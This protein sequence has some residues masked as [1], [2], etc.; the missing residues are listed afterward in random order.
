MLSPGSIAPRPLLVALRRMALGVV[1]LWIAS[2]CR[3]GPAYRPPAVA[4]PQTWI[5]SDHSRLRGAPLDTLSWWTSFDDPIL[6]ELM[7]EARRQNLTLLHAGT[8]IMEARAVL[9]VACGRLG[10]QDQAALGGVSHTHISHNSPSEA[11]ASILQRNAF[12]Q[13]TLG[14]GAAW[15]LDF[16]GK[17]RRAVT[18]ASADVDAAIE[19][20]NDAA[21]MLLAETA[22][23]YLQLRTLEYRLELARQNVAIQDETLQ[24]TEARAR[25]G[26]GTELDSLQATSILRE[27]QALV[28]ALEAQHRISNNRLCILLGIPPRD[29]SSRIGRTAIVPMPRA[30]LAVGVPADL[31]RRRPDIRR[32]E[33]ELAAQ[34]E[35]IGIAIADFYPQLS[36]TGNVGLD[37]LDLSKLYSPRSWAAVAGPSFRWN[38]LNYGRIQNGVRVQEARYQG[39]LLDYQN[40]VLKA[41]EEAENAIVR[42][43]AMHE[44]VALLQ[45]SVEAAQLSIR[46]ALAA[47][48]L[49]VMDYQRVFLLQT[50]LVVKQDSLAVAQ[51]ELAQSLVGVYKSMGGGWQC[52]QIRH[53][54]K[55]SSE[56]SDSSR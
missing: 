40:A 11:I 23:S 44:R 17:Y 6:N 29:L 49:G 43:L 39:L 24:T 53:L 38:I 50:Q 15:E 18:A 42:F 35:R 5:D 25:A 28:P 36:I 12:D 34:S 31:L 19:N 3:V 13:W 9:G 22:Q 7:E 37:A 41:D 51:G 14:I 8:R 48:R 26:K 32:A 52:D 4:L 54:P 20:H 27:T 21:V 1:A 2:G 30:E 56:T 16:W 33:R 47:Y 46:E 45:S 10:P 55:S